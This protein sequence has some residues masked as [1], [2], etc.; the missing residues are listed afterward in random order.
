[1]ASRPFSSTPLPLTDRPSDYETL[2]EELEARPP[3][4]LRRAR[5]HHRRA[6]EALRGGAY[7][8]LSAETRAQLVQRF[9][10]NMKAL[11]EALDE[12]LDEALTATRPRTAAPA[13][14]RPRRLS[15]SE[16]KPGSGN[17]CDQGTD[18]GW[19][20][21]RPPPC[22]PSNRSIRPSPVTSPSAGVGRRGT[23][24]SEAA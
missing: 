4:E 19:K 8:S 22:P 12:A 18:G 11:N 16:R 1:M 17:A 9:R 6:L 13:R 21:R 15:F 14:R 5:T 3:D 7:E 2:V 10:I 23:P 20:S 24:R